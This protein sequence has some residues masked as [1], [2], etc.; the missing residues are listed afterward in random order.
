MS[1]QEDLDTA[2]AG[3]APQVAPR[4][5]GSVLHHDHV[6]V[7][8]TEVEA[9]A[10]P[11]DP[12]SHAWRGE[13]ARN[14]TMFGP[15]GHLYVYSMHGHHCCNVVCADPGTP[16]GLLIRAGE[17][18]AGVDLARERRAAHRRTAIPEHQLARGPG[19]L[20][21]CLGITRS[22][23]GTDLRNH[24]GPWLELRPPLPRAEVRSGPRVGVPRAVDVAWRFWIA[25]DPSVSSFRP[26]RSSR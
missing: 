26:A 13:T 9:Y 6:A 22:D 1:R 17:V 19:N 25:D 12:A 21:R 23:D 7:R 24:C 10:G 5:L 4:L 14:R 3:T 2:L 15:R 18:V 11:D 16:T 20:T 8:I